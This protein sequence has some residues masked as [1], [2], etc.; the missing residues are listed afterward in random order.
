MMKD[1]SMVPKIY[2][3]NLSPRLFQMELLPFTRVTVHLVK[4]II[5]TF[6]DYQTLVLN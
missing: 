6:R 4:G 5:R 2:V 1:P 3:V